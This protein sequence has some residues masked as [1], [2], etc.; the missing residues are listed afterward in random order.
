MKSSPVYSPFTS[1]ALKIVGL[2]MIVSSLLDYLFLAIP[3]NPLQREWQ[4]GY[5]AQLVDRGILPMVGIAFLLI[6]Y[7]V[8]KSAGVSASERRPIVQ[9]LRFWALLLSSLLG[10]IFLLLIPLHINNVVQQS[11][12]ALKQINQRANQAQV[13]IDVRAQQ[14]GATVKDPK[15]LA[16]LKQQLTDLDQA[17]ETGKVPAE[18]LPQAKAYRQLLQTITQNPTKAISQEVDAAK[19]KIGK[20]KQELEKQTKSGAWKS[21]LRTSLSS[22]LLALG[23]IGIGWTGLRGSG[24]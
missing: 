21:A 10:L 7:W 20:D 22:L 2:I 17:I 4:L 11:E 13:Q 3:F 14:I 1:L 9:D 6:G 15:G 19:A 23:Y 5:M 24:G 18:Q 8:D 16:Q 12:E